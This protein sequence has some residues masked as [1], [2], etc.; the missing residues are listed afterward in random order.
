MANPTDPFHAPT[1]VFRGISSVERPIDKE[2]GWSIVPLVGG[3]VD[4][5]ISKY[6]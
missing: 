1:K 5:D 6:T 3:G 4:T 2:A